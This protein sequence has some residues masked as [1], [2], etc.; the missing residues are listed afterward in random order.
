M[1]VGMSHIG[2]RSSRG[3]IEHSSML[4]VGCGQDSYIALRSSLLLFI[5]LLGYLR[6]HTWYTIAANQYDQVR[7]SIIYHQRV[8]DNSYAVGLGGSKRSISDPQ[9]IR[10]DVSGY[11]PYRQSD[12][13][14][15]FCFV[16]CALSGGVSYAGVGQAKV[17]SKLLRVLSCSWVLG[18][19][20]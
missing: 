3:E 6:S 2:T 16:F 15:S 9:P 17:S 7:S 1:C 14:C 20:Q 10:R 19:L 13:V 5:F 4:A 18:G 11:L 12:R 8:K